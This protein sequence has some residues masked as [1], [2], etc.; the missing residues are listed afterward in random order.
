GTDQITRLNGAAAKAPVATLAWGLA[1]MSIIGLPP[2][3]GFLAKWLLLTSA[4]RFGYW[5][6][7]GVILAGRLLASMYIFRVLWHAF[8]T[9]DETTRDPPIVARMP[10]SMPLATLFLA[11]L[12]VAIGVRATELFALIG[13]G[14]PFVGKG[15]P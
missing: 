3:G 7:A 2:S 9:E 5:P 14:S 6:Y 15:G 4:I 8:L 12:I 10:R 13:I 1:G 11:I